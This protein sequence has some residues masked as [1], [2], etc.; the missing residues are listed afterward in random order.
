MKAVTMDPDPWNWSVQDVQ[1]F[2][3]DEAA[4]YTSDMPHGR[5][6][7]LEP[8]LKTLNDNDVNGA[9]LL[10]TIDSGA[11]RDD[12]GVVSLG[13]RGSI[14]HCIV[15]LRRQS[16]RYNS[17]HEPLRLQTPLSL[18][19]HAP[20][21][22][23]PEE[24]VVVSTENIGEHV[25]SGEVQ[26]QDS[27]GRKRRKLD[28]SKLQAQQDVEQTLG[29]AS[30]L[31]TNQGYLGDSACP[32]DELFYGE[33][34]FGHEIGELHST[35]SVL[36]V[37]DNEYDDSKEPSFQFTYQGKPI[38]E[39]HY[40]Y[41]QMRYLFNKSK[42]DSLD[43][44]NL[45]RQ[46]RGACG[47][48]PYRAN[49]QGK[50]R[51]ATVFQFRGDQAERIAVRENVAYLDGPPP[52]ESSAKSAGEWDFLIPKHRR[53]E[54]EVLP[55][56]GESE[57]GD[58][59]TLGQT[60]DDEEED[61]AS[62][63]AESGNLT[64]ERAVEIIDDSIRSTTL[65]WHDRLPKLELKKAWTIWKKM[66]R[67]R[68][69][70]DLLIESAQ[71]K[72]EHFS[73]RLRSMKDE[74]LM[75]EWANGQALVKRCEA[76]APTVED[77]EEQRWMISVWK[78]RHEPAHVV[79]HGTRPIQITS[80]AQRKGERSIV[81]PKGD[82]L[83]VSPAPDASA[84]P[85]N[86]ATEEIVYEADDEEFHTPIQSPR[87]SP[88]AHSETLEYPLISDL[89]AEAADETGRVM[90]ET[91]TD[92]QID[93]ATGHNDPGLLTTGDNSNLS[94]NEDSEAEELPSPGQF[95]TPR[96]RAVGPNTG[97]KMNTAPIDL[98]TLSSDSPTP[99]KTGRPPGTLK[100]K[101]APSGDPHSATATE[102]DSWGFSTLAKDNDRLRI[103]IKLLRQAG[104][105]VRDRVNL[106]SRKFG[107]L[108]FTSQLRAAA[109]ANHKKTIENADLN[110]EFS[111][112]MKEAAEMYV[113]WLF[114]T[115]L[116]QDTRKLSR[117]DWDTVIDRNQLSI[118]SNMLASILLKKDSK[119]FIDPKPR[120]SEPSSSSAL[121]IIS[122]G[123]EI[124]R[125]Q[126]TPHKK[127][128]RA[129]GRSQTAQDSRNSALQRQ[130]RYNESQIP[131]SA[132][133]VAM[134]ASDPSHSSIEINPAKKEEHDFIYVCDRIA[135]K[136][137][138]H[139]I[140]GTRFLWREITAD[141]EYGGQGCI[142]A[143][144]MGLG[145]TMQ[146]I[147][148]LVSL[149]EASQSPTKAVHLQLPAHLRP[150]GRK[151]RQLRTLILCP[152]GLIQNWRREL[153][154]WAAQELGNAWSLE[155]GRGRHSAPL[156]EWMRFGGVLLV[157]Y[158][159]FRL[160]ISGKKHRSDPNPTRSEEETHVVK[161][162]LEGPELVIADEA[163][164]LRNE[165]AGITKSAMRFQTES[166]VALTGTP[167]SNDVQEIYSLVSWVAPGYLGDPQEFRSYYTEPIAEGLWQ[168]STAYERRVS[169]KKL[170]V[171][172]AEIQPK[173][174]RANIE[175]L[176]GSLKS[177]TEF[178]ITVPLR[179]VQLDLY[180]RYIA[181]LL[182]GDRSLKASQVTIFGWLACLTL[183]ANHP[184]CF[185]E[186]LLA[187]PPEK[188]QN[189]QKGKQNIV[190]RDRAS[191]NE[192]GS[193][194]PA[195]TAVTTIADQE[196]GPDAA[197]EVPSDEQIYDE[198][199]EKLGFS[200][201]M[202]Q[203]ILNGFGGDMDPEFSAKVTVFLTL[204]NYSLECKDKV[205]VFSTS[206]P[207]LEYLD[208]MFHNLG[209]R[210][211][212]I[213]GSTQMGKRMQVLEDF[214]KDQFDIMLV[215]TRAGGVGLNIQ[216]ANRV[217]IF[218]FGFNPTL[219]EQAI[220]RA[221]RLGQ[222]KSV[223]VYR[224]VAGGTFETNIYNKQL[225]KSSLAQR[226]VDKKNPRRNAERNT[227]E[228][229]YE[230]KEVAQ[231]NITE[232]AGKDPN[233]LDRLLQ[234][235]GSASEG[236]R[237]TLIRAIRTMETLQEEVMDAPLDE[238]EQREV[239]EEI[240]QGRGRPR[241][242]KAAHA[243]PTAIASTM[244]GLH[245]PTASRPPP[246]TFA[247]PS[248]YPPF[249]QAHSRHFMGGLPMTQPFRGN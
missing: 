181:S 9:I 226:V 235:H 3:R 106:C 152:P 129:V 174:N 186:K 191:S 203:A 114:P 91:D 122:S 20:P 44:E 101:V 208:Q 22:I 132:R 194:T 42:S 177:K 244:P 85:G 214:H 94:P 133:L 58:V 18:S 111:M 197:K 102:V 89:N 73:A 126:D 169:I 166:R 84:R 209:R 183:L 11:L 65:Q 29:A 79:Q 2:F 202:V 82:R 237:D 223:F 192:S 213:D 179:E 69:I 185:H 158:Q 205:L 188:K 220:G 248:A 5:L 51:S 189:K 176:R 184:R 153:D 143:H 10:T 156:E 180:K 40:V 71:A 165:K 47:I 27:Q 25:R 136:M 19:A 150:K 229:L 86:N 162:L 83:R 57:T 110:H 39:T 96:N 231:E 148:L 26:V 198:H 151:H 123:D 230:P 249:L 173:V 120:S 109:F 64:S 225:F 66:K 175:V 118:F 232:W 207:T 160:A 178:V 167:I 157:G 159:M 46:G 6:P 75:N 61:Q 70:R 125:Q 67:S 54:D 52:T 138:A 60:A 130:S 23:Q 155:S 112:T 212:R 92:L 77:R 172:H 99:K 238:E 227:R 116:E 4:D 121:V 171:L 95:V 124:S 30:A 100:K 134:I 38:G 164:N 215:S 16:T 199:I 1:A 146:T 80:K 107:R 103:L 182:S 104:P 161:M 147:A 81:V 241:G 14:I 239:N 140:D 142:L 233:V 55:L 190:P 28:I 31:S 128:K 210:F 163:H 154:R 115:L 196:V 131:D 149:N 243:G 139:Q 127:R 117:G 222:T 50:A 245:S 7:L 218:D 228:Y 97:V 219:E 78:T 32:I 105:E 204:L 135:K 53:D 201:E 88:D 63:E 119:L 41:S 145:K 170:K 224:F 168:D 59:E 87:T 49:L 12:C 206:I 246:S 72:I 200:E 8:F 211:G 141:G 137:K 45:Q 56:Y 76:L 93:S 62:E 193:I 242:R 221:Y 195:H 43:L 48:L 74:M 33:T 187:P 37:H 24:V 21:A 34:E 36:I 13:V 216:G 247:G 15:K 35:G 108:T 217:F 98:T 68:T 236:K 17:Q 144:T 234:Q 90:G 240:Q 113:E